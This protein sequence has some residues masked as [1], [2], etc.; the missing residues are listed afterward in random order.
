L[1]SACAAGDEQGRSTRSRHPAK[2]P[3]GWEKARPLSE[4][5]TAQAEVGDQNA[6]RE[7][8]RQARSVAETITEE[9]A[10][11]NELRE[12]AKGLGAAGDL[13]G[14]TSSTHPFLRH[15]C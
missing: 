8:G 5:A 11:V 1:H 7:T 6:A 12:A 10:R 15:G 4:L 3:A 14:T 9:Q 2:L 13:D